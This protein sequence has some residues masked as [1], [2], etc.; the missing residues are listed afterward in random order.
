MTINSSIA[1][2]MF[3]FSIIIFLVL[4]GGFITG[5]IFQKKNDTIQNH[6]FCWFISSLSLLGFLILSIII[7]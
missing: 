6:K 4:W 3:T 1:I 5:C 2:I 7:L